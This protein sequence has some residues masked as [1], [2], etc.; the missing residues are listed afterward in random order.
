[1]CDCPENAEHRGDI[2][3]PNAQ[4]TEISRLKMAKEINIESPKVYVSELAR[5][6]FQSS[7][8][9]IKQEKNVTIDEISDIT[10]KAKQARII[11]FAQ[12]QHVAEP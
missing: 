6:L 3:N 2:L 10:P 8:K 9:E 11:P 12:Y 1:M 5:S 7:E 4:E